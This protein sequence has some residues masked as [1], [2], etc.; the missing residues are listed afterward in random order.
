MPSYAFA[1]NVMFLM[2]FCALRETVRICC[3]LP[4]LEGMFAPVCMCVCVC[5]CDAISPLLMIG[6]DV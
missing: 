5:V 3:W 2:F 6:R 1:T 4:T